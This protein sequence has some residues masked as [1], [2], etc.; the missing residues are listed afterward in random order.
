MI[1]DVLMVQPG[2]ALTEILETPATDEQVSG[3]LLPSRFR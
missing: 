3:S 2:D 1:V